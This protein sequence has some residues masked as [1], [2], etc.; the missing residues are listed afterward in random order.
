MD[1]QEVGAGEGANACAAPT[2][3]PPDGFS[4]NRYESRVREGKGKE[5][6]REG[7]ESHQVNKK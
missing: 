2:D 7:D 4:Y 3:K 6:K 1:A 5:G